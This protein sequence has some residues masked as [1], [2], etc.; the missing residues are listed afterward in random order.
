MEWELDHH[1]KKL[2]HNLWVWLTDLEGAL[3]N[4]GLWCAQYLLNESHASMLLKLQVGSDG[5]LCGQVEQR[6][7]AAL[8]GFT[9][10]LTHNLYVGLWKGRE[11]IYTY[12]SALLY[13]VY[14]APSKRAQSTE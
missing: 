6:Q 5:M 14:T 3:S 13:K 12:I 11:R 1:Q 10:F 7:A 8:D 2:D 9:A 4:R